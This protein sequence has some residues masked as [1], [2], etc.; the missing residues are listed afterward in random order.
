MTTK[1]PML[2]RTF[3]FLTVLACSGKNKHGQIMY[4]CV[5]T[6]GTT[7]NV[8]GVLL[9]NGSVKS[10]GKCIEGRRLKGRGYPNLK[11]KRF[12]TLTVQAEHGRTIWGNVLWVCLCDCGKETTV[13]TSELRSGHTQSCG[14]GQR[15]TLPSGEASFNQLLSSY[16]RGA[17]NRKLSFNISKTLFK[18]L[19]SSACFYCGALP[20]SVQ[21]HGTITTPYIYNGIDRVDNRYGY[22][23]KNCVPCCGTCN[24]MKSALSKEEFLAHIEQIHAHQKRSKK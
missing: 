5:C 18:I 9:R 19:T 7:K 3:T 15:R 13:I 12:G 20:K 6:C 24:A 22:S 23:K 21:L 8:L 16:I 17:K 10:C 14:C 1:I 4:K 2:G 11:G